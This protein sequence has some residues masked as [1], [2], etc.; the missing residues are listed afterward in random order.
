MSTMKKKVGMD[1]EV[2]H[3]VPLIREHSEIVNIHF[4][5]DLYDCIQV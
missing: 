2:S 5:L 3:D 1:I 4:H